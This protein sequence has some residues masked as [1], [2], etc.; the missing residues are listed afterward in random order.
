ME[1]E[2]VS[3]EM[4][5]DARRIAVAFGRKS[6]KNIEVYPDRFID[7]GVDFASIRMAFR[8]RNNGLKTV[9]AHFLRG[10]QWRISLETGFSGNGKNFQ[11]VR[12]DGLHMNGDALAPE[13]MVAIYKLG[14]DL[15]PLQRV[16]NLTLTYHEQLELRLSMP[17]EFWPQKWLDE[18]VL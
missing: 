8:Y 5:R 15:E 4:Q 14:L 3:E 7:L 17:R 10:E 11:Y 1:F 18:E 13:M 2:D 12:S 16:F 6:K 9:V